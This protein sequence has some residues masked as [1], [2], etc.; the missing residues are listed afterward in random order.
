MGEPLCAGSSAALRLA[1]PRH[2]LAPAGSLSW[3]DVVR[4]LLFEPASLDEWVAPGWAWDDDP[5]LITPA[6]EFRR[7]QGQ[8][9]AGAT[10]PHGSRAA[11]ATALRCSTRA[12]HSPRACPSCSPQP[13]TR[14][15]P[16]TRA[17]W[18][19]PAPPSLTFRYSWGAGAAP[20]TPPAAP[21]PAAAPGRLPHPGPARQHALH[22]I[23]LSPTGAPRPVRRAAGAR[24]ALPRIPAGGDRALAGRGLRLFAG[25][26]PAPVLP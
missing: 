9:E 25:P 21:A 16:H 2:A 12:A 17:S 13:C 19:R 1:Q 6:S 5:P 10:R 7:R 3:D 14:A 26:V 18:R 11:P 4:D 15:T 20:C 22:P 23:L 24:R 8:G